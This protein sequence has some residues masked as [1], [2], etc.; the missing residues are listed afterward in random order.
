MN[1]RKPNSYRT[2]GKY[3]LMLKTVDGKL[4]TRLDFSPLNAEERAST[5]L[6]DGT[7]VIIYDTATKQISQ[8][9]TVNTPLAGVTTISQRI[10]G[11]IDPNAFK[12]GMARLSF[13]T[14]QDSTGRYAFYAAPSAVLQKM[15]GVNGATVSDFR[16]V[17]D[18]QDDAVQGTEQVQ[19]TPDGEKI[20]TDVN[21]QY[22]MVQDQPV[23]TGQ[24]VE[25][26]HEFPNK[27]D[28]GPDLLPQ[29][30]NTDDI[31]E[32]TQEQNDQLTAQGQS[33]PLDITT[34]DRTDPNYTLT[35]F[36]TYDN[37]S[38]NATPDSDL[39]IPGGAQ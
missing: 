15:T 6:T 17:F 22:Q 23:L 5:V 11:R 33:F 34:G 12:S 36:T 37:I 13:D 14:T 8:R 4:R 21:Y 25:E 35:T 20:T 3:R 19:V 29:V 1:D 32:I 9:L 27:L 2:M 26:H 10:M 7:D 39:R 24:V 18:L 28:A 31:E 30:V 16:L 38:V